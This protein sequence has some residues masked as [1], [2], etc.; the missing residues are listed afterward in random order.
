MRAAFPLPRS[1]R[2]RLTALYGSLLLLAGGG[3]VALV[4]VLFRNGLY[5]SI[6]GALTTTSV[7]PGMRLP[8]PAER[9]EPGDPGD[10]DHPGPTPSPEQ[11]EQYRITQNLS[12]AAEQ[13]TLHDLLLVSLVAL[14]VFAVLS[15]CL[16][17]WMAGRVLR[18]VGVITETA[19]RLS[20]ENLHERI[21]LQAPPGEL[22]RLADTF[23]G[24]LD[25][26]EHL[27]SAQRRFAANAAHE[28][29]TPLAVQRSAAEIGLAGDPPPEKVARIRTKLI[30]TATASEHLIES[31]LLLA[32]SEEGLS[33]AGT[34]EVDLAALAAAELAACDPADPAGVAN[35]TVQRTLAPLPVT[36]DRLLLGHLIRNLLSNAI[37]HN[38]TAGRITLGTSA[39]GLLTVSNTGAQIEPAEVPALLEPF[40]RRTERQHTPGEG[41]GL[42]LS[43]VA[44]IARAHGAEL[45]AEANPAPEGGLTVRI[46]FPVARPQSEVKSC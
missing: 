14:A 8:V 7:R 5:A 43:I 33:P 32:V 42:G 4:N 17:W 19:R 23:D 25:R 12:T 29:R 40:R 10:P 21:A 9:M 27:V 34:E 31:L 41:A 22:K 30:D 35:L 38:R 2:A 36:G 15:M 28:L 45:A 1:E 39:D 13:A 26:M 46:R 44:S 37:R 11:L 24:M 20:G 6:S 3:L 16:A 18:P